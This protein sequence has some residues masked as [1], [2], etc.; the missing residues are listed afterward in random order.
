LKGKQIARSVQL[1][2]CPGT[3]QIYKQALREGLIEIF[4]DAECAIAQPACGMC[5]GAYTPLG[6]GD[7]CI[8][9]STV[10]GIG[11]MGNPKSEIYLG[12]EATVAASCVAGVLADARE[13]I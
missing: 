12:S 4:L 1:T 7:V 3:V 6:A 13:C 10:N 8:S 9:T 5:N 11:R 2:V